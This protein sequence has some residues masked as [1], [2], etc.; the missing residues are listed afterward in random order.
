MGN[1]NSPVRI[2]AF[3]DYQCPYCATMF[4]LLEQLM[5]KYPQ[6]VCVILKHFP[7]RMHPFAEK[8]SLAK[9]LPL[10]NRINTGSSAASILKIIKV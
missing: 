1:K 2:V 5:D 3:L 9:P 10:Q 6:K 8:A 7:L 4:P